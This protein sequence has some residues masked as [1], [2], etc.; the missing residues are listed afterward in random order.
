VLLTSAGSPSNGQFQQYTPG[1]TAAS[2]PAPKWETFDTAIEEARWRL[3][4]LYLDPWIGIRNAS[5]VSDT[6]G[7]GSDESDFTATAGLGL[8]GYLPFGERG[9]LSLYGLPEYTAWAESDERNRLNG[10]YGAGLFLFGSRVTSSL[11][12]TLD[13][14]QQF[15]TSQVEALTHQR[16]ESVAAGLELRLVGSLHLFGTA[17]E[18][19]FENLSRDVPSGELFSSVDREERVVRAGIRLRPLDRVSVGFAVERS[20]VEFAAGVPERNNSGTSPVFEVQYEGPYFDATLDLAQRDLEPDEGS[21]FQPYDAT[22]GH[23]RLTLLPE[24][25]LQPSVYAA[26]NLVYAV[27]GA[28]VA[29]DDEKAGL[30]LDLTLGGHGRFRVYA[31]RGRNDYQAAGLSLGR[32]DD[33][34]A[35]GTELGLQLGRLVGLHLGADRRS[36]DSNLDTFDR[37]ITTVSFGLDLRLT[38]AGVGWPA[39]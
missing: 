16:R 7:Q 12:G 20:V 30:R 35:Y 32:R 4:P 23:V 24:R 17:S 2:S 37:D 29:F 6:F 39:D 1:G 10:R 9:V 19:T 15:F 36:Y 14:Q 5:Y 8:R 27:G 18:S 22:T 21:T 28:F 25:A 3:G 38:A 13:E 11:T 26:R 31:E 33:V 34:F